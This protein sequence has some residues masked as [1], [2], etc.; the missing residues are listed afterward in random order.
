MGALHALLDGVLGRWEARRVKA[1]AHR[2]SGRGTNQL[3]RL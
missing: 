3:R 1:I 2:P